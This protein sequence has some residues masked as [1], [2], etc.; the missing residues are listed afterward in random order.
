MHYASLVILIDNKGR[1]LT[2]KRSSHS[3]FP[4]QWGLPGG[5]AEEGEEDWETAIR[6]LRE[7]TSVVI[8]KEDLKPL[9]QIYSRDKFF[10][11][12]WAKCEAPEIILDSEHTDWLWIPKDE[13][14]EV[15]SIPTDEA[16]WI[17]LKS[18]Q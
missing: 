10:H 8:S 15:I 9:T 4:S 17:I 7:E 18:I 12:F 3:S 11:F 14:K 2:L 13:L 5:R 16:V 1:G 6:E